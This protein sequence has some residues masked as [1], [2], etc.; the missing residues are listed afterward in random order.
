MQD[1]ANH[2]KDRVH[3]R[4]SEGKN[5]NDNR[6]GC[7]TLRGTQ[8]RENCETESKEQTPRIS[9]ENPGRIKIVP[10]E[11]DQRTDKQ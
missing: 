9:Q 1:P 11:S 10:E 2:C 5:G 6:K 7:R 3:N 8:D 4:E